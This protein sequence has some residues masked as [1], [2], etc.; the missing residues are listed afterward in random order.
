VVSVTAKMEVLYDRIT[1]IAPDGSS[2]KRGHYVDGR[3]QKEKNKSP[4]GNTEKFSEGEKG[5]V[6][7][8]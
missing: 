1:F 3:R 2:R 6:M 8:R 7:G 5:R 4:S